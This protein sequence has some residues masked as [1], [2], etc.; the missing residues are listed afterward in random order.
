MV[1]LVFV[2]LCIRGTS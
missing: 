1:K 2:G